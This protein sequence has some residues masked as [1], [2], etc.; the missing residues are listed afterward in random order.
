[1]K[2]YICT[3]ILDGLFTKGDRGRGRVGWMFGGG[4]A[5]WGGGRGAE[6]QVEGRGRGRSLLFF[7]FLRNLFVLVI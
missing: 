2:Q 4:E 6:G 1:M 3:T 5:G 7:Y